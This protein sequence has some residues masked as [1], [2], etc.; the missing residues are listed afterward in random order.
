MQK[1]LHN[2]TPLKFILIISLFFN[3]A[4][5]EDGISEVRNVDIQSKEIELQSDDYTPQPQDAKTEEAVI[6]NS[7]TEEALVEN[8]KTEEALVENSNPVKQNEAKENELEAQNIVATPTL[9]ENPI[10]IPEKKVSEIIPTLSL[11]QTTTANLKNNAR[12][13][14]GLASVISTNKYEI[15]PNLNNN[16]I[17]IENIGYKTTSYANLF[18]GYRVNFGKLGLATELGMNGFGINKYGTR[19]NDESSK[20]Y[21]TSQN[22]CRHA[23]NFDK[24]LC[25]E[26]I[27]EDKN[28]IYISQ[29]IGYYAENVNKSHFSYFI[30]GVDKRKN[31]ITYIENIAYQHVSKVIEVSELSYLFG[32][33]YE[34]T[35][36]NTGFFIEINGFDATPQKL[37]DELKIKLHSSQF[38]F[39]I[40]YH[41]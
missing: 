6:E 30:L 12:F 32:V 39:G 18:L 35:F 14:I 20:N 27:I 13:F 24:V 10:E 2:N 40:K 28:R 41:F 23:S 33:G 11:P 15:S 22:Y 21:L 9:D 38:K 1:L 25:A 26:V 19:D 3:V 36:K 34:F 4:T 17:D 29:K 8:A 16:N 37:S 7:K 5:A 31:K